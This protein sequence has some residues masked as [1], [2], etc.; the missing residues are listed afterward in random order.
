VAKINGIGVKMAEYKTS[1]YNHSHS[2][3]EVSVKTAWSL[4]IGK[5]IFLEICDDGSKNRKFYANFN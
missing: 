4:S 1:T 3:A 5:N 2:S